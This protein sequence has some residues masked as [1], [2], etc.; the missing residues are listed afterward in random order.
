MD[1][2]LWRHADAEAGALDLARRLTAKGVKQAERM[3][4]WLDKHLPDRCHILVS[5][6]ER[7]KQTAAPLK[8]K[9]KVV[10]ELAP[11]VGVDSVLDA[12]GWPDAATPV[13]IVG[14]QPTLGEVAA[15]LVSGKVSAWSIRKGGVW[16]LSHRDRDGASSVIVKLVIGP[17][18]V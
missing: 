4:D 11:G 17:D 9:F 8:R 13:L 15:F 7:A 6:A 18:F 14:H 2:I 16:W 10:P 12:A 1:L 3:A 5:P